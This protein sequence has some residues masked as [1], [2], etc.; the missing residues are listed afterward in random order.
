MS[1]EMAERRKT[2]PLPKL[3]ITLALLILHAEPV[4]ATVIFPF[5]PEFIRRTGITNGDEKKTGY[6]AGIIV[7]FGSLSR[8]QKEAK[9]YTRNLYSSSQNAFLCII[10]EKL[11]TI[12]EDGLS[13]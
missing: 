7:R 12:L 8:K 3:Q 9:T 4:A 6:Y 2:T 13:Y 1:T 5:I 11:Q 10:G